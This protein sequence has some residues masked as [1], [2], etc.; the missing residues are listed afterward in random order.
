MTE[1]LP[2][3]EVL[4]ELPDAA[5][6]PSAAPSTVG[7]TA[8]GVPAS[9]PFDARGQG[10]V[11]NLRCAWWTLREFFVHRSR[12]AR[13]HLMPDRPGLWQ[14]PV[15]AAL[16]LYPIL[17]AL[18]VVVSRYID[19]PTDNK[20]QSLMLASIGPVLTFVGVYA[21]AKLFRGS[22]SARQ[23]L[24]L[25]TSMVLSMVMAISISTAVSN[26]VADAVGL[27]LDEDALQD[28]DPRK[29][30]DMGPTSVMAEQIFEQFTVKACVDPD[31]EPPFGT[32][33]LTRIQLAYIQC[34]SEEV[35]ACVER[36][37]QSYGDCRRQ[38]D[39]EGPE[40]GGARPI[41][42]PEVESATGSQSHTEQAGED[43]TTATTMSESGNEAPPTAE[44]R[45]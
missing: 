22:G 12:F 16:F 11:F 26:A 31:L 25:T 43:E 15:R 8:D 35:K 7:A 23:T 1:E 41:A 28:F 6:A 34:V 30:N 32:V 2:D 10:F 14:V 24:A 33:E 37:G 18:G 27:K 29:M 36:T 17:I 4:S 20:T 19:I 9:S 44:K 42:A 5:S 3:P 21:C 40:K 39:P 13:V 45:P 38:V